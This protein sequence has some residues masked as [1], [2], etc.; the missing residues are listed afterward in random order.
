MFNS[1]ML[2]N[3]DP[4]ENTQAAATFRS[5]L[6]VTALSYAF[7]Q[8]LRSEFK[9]LNF[10]I[11]DATYQQLYASAESS[12]C[13]SASVNIGGQ[14]FAS[15]GGTATISVTAPPGCA[16]TVLN[17]PSWIGFTSATSGRG[18]GTVGYEVLSNEGPERT[19]TMT[20]GGTSFTI[21][22]QGSPT[23]VLNLIGSLA[24]L[25]AEEN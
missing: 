14:A 9:A 17:S 16:W 1:S 5:T 7:L 21:E 3:Y 20:I 12:I 10:P 11:D 15:T 24:H 6:M 4:H 8:D 19:V 23:S 2:A 22:Q 25:A 18:N 13:S